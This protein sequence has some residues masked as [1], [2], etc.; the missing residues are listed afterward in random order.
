MPIIDLN[1]VEGYADAVERQDLLRDMAFLGVPETLCGIAVAPMTFRHL[2]WLQTIRS[3]F[4]GLSSLEEKTAHLD[5]AAFFKTLAP[6]ARP[7]FMMPKSPE[8]AA[9]MKSVGK[10]K[11]P[12]ALKGV[13]EFVADTFMDA[14]GGGEGGNAA[15]YFSVGAAAVHRLCSKYGGI[16]PN[17]MNY[18]S[19]VDMPLKAAF[20]LFKCL[21]REE[22]P[23]AILFNGL[24]D[25]IKSRWIE[26]QT[27]P[28]N[29]QN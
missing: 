22:N 17:P 12:N 24:S 23:K 27:S 21:K 20:Q 16:D 13:R 1:Q 18:P 4:I 2:L 9:F 6:L 8:L 15:S 19:A 26:Q 7:S 5:V 29:S 10:I 3:P 25:K 11:L 28:D 14:P